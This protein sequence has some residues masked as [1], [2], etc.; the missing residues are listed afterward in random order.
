ME[1]PPFRSVDES[2]ED[3]L[4]DLD[5]E[6][7]LLIGS[8]TDL[9]G[10][11]TVIDVL[12]HLYLIARPFVLVSQLERMIRQLISACV[13]DDALITAARRAMAGKKYEDQDDVPTRLTEMTMDD[14][15]WLVR[16]SKNW[17]DHFARAFSA[18]GSAFQRDRV[19]EHLKEIR[20]LR[21]QIV[22]LR[23]SPTETDLRALKRHGRWLRNR[24]D[25]FIR[26]D[27]S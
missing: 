22:H 25:M 13:T 8:K 2:P 18:S 3:L 21:N 16:Y 20:D 23:S 10:I 1:H 26:S 14:Y 12:R 5:H 24:I 15:V 17:T 11:V 19:E 7:A 6:P 27:D 9:V 4:D